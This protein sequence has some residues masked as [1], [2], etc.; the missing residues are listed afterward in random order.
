LLNPDEN[1]FISA[2]QASTTES[3]IVEE[4]TELPTFP[5]TPPKAWNAEYFR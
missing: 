4:T 3:E 5:L 2:A 1:D